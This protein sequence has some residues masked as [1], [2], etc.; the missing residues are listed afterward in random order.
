MNILAI[1]DSIIPSDIKKDAKYFT[2]AR[3]VIGICLVLILAATLYSLLYLIMG[4]FWGFVVIAIGGVGYVGCVVQIR[5]TKSLAIMENEAVLLMLYV[6]AGLSLTTGGV[7]APNTM[8]LATVP[9]MAIILT[10]ILR[11]IIWS[12]ITVLFVVSMFVW[13]LLGNEIPML[14]EFSATKLEVFQGIINAGLILFI[15]GFCIL[16]EILKRDAIEDSERL[17]TEAEKN[18]AGLKKSSKD[19]SENLNALETTV[20]QLTNVSEQVN[21]SANVLS[22][23]ATNLSDGTSAQAATLEEIASSMNQ[24]E[25]QTKDIDGNASQAHQLASETLEIVKKSNNQMKDMLQSMQEINE[26]SVNITRIIK[27]IDEIASQTNLLALNAAVE[28]A[29][30]GKFGKGFSVVAAEVRSLASRSA[31]AAR[32]TTELIEA[33]AEEIDKGVKNADLTAELMGD[34]NTSMEQASKLVSEIASACKEQSL[35]I[36]EINNGLF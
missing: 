33:S 19:L 22:A 3:T 23:S 28:A 9:V 25:V 18:A 32:S 30:A 6:Q 21:A 16:Y 17:W 24:I 10:R 36:G 34:I 13:K 31:D 1:I 4:H 12:L 35:G 20:G 29:R 2:R 8:W 11:G 5:Y 26:T 15:M 27:V 7:L 14:V